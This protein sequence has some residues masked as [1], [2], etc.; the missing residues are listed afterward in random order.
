MGEGT[1]GRGLPL[2]PPTNRVL[3]PLLIANL[4]NLISRHFYFKEHIFNIY[5]LS[6]FYFNLE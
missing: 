3:M 1:R 2:L 4:F 6:E 5:D